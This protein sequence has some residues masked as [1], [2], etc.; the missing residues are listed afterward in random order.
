[1]LFCEERNSS[2]GKGESFNFHFIFVCIW[3]ILENSI[4]SATTLLKIVNATITLFE[5]FIT[6]DEDIP[7][8]LRFIKK[9]K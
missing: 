1:M 6:V 8:Q 5:I 4:E 9:K 7:R 3:E 2:C